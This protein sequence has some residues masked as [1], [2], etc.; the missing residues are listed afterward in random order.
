MINFTFFLRINITIVNII[1]YLKNYSMD[2]LI[3]KMHN[4]IIVI[5][6]QN[7]RSSLQ[8]SY[9]S[10]N[11][12]DIAKKKTQTKTFRYIVTKPE[13]PNWGLTLHTA[14]FAQTPPMGTYPPSEHPHPYNLLWNRGRILKEFQL[15]YI[16]EGSGIFESK[17]S[18]KQTVKSG[19]LILI[20]KN[21]WHR[22]KPH[23]KTGWNEYW[24][25]FQGEIAERLFCPPFFSQRF[26]VIKVKKAWEFLSEFL[27]LIQEMIESPNIEGYIL[28][29]K[30]I[31]LLAHLHHWKN[32]TYQGGSRI[33]CDIEEAKV[34]LSQNY[35][36]KINFPSL[37][38]KL[39]ISYTKFR[40]NF[41]EQTGIPPN[42]YLQ[43]I[44]HEQARRLLCYSDKSIQD[45]ATDTGFHSPYYFSRSFKKRY[46]KSPSRLRK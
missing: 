5:H 26:P 8:K 37:A 23:Q 7:K 27:N 44:R 42:Q 35:K 30:I 33:H 45:I 20:F 34:Y 6:A 18:K 14:G 29:A 25:G 3:Q 4:L 24:I 11:N 39:G 13:D 41:R 9:P 31:P 2:R 32:H 16:D 10:K 43:Q 28:T 40:R 38:T 46:S 12:G 17:D 15:V 36:K 22:Y 21:Q 1:D 19:D